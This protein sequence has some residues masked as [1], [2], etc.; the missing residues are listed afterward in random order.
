VHSANRVTVVESIRVLTWNLFHCRDG[1]PG[2]TVG[3]TWRRE[4]VERDGYVHLNRKYCDE[5]ADV[6]RATEA[7]LVMLQEVPPRAIERL[8]RRS[9]AT[10]VW[11][12]RTSPRLGPPGLRGWLGARNPDLWKTHEGNANVILTGPRLGAEA[13]SARGIPLNPRRL[14][15]RAARRYSLPVAEV[16]HWAL[17]ARMALTVRLVMPGGSTFTAVC[18]HHHGATDPR[19]LDDEMGLLGRA[20]DDIPGA[21]ILGGDINA[22]PEHPGFAVWRASGLHDG[23][24]DPGIGIDRILV[25]G[26]ELVGAPRRLETSVRELPLATA[27]GPRRVLLSDHDPV[28][29]TVMVPG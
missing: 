27:D 16:A 18:V 17:E 26:L 15:A 1:H 4:A 2:A 9:G 29:A 23:T 21:V 13:G 11:S 7:D 3:S 14:I 25:R 6:I 8:R 5:M 19:Q 10:A 22:G 24:T 20:L 12:V 28:Q